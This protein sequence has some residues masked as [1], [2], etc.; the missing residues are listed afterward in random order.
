MSAWSD[1]EKTSS[2]HIATVLL[3]LIIFTPGLQLELLFHTTRFFTVSIFQSLIKA[4][5][6]GITLL[7]ISTP[8]WV[9]IIEKT[10]GWGDD[11]GNTYLLAISFVAIFFVSLCSSIVFS[12]IYLLDIE[13]SQR[14]AI[15]ALCIP[16][17]LIPL[18]VLLYLLISSKHKKQKSENNK[19]LRL[20]PGG[21]QPAQTIHSA[22]RRDERRSHLLS[23]QKKK[24]ILTRMVFL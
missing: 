16:A 6:I 22:A 3:P 1:I 24:T 8:L 20:G 15:S 18:F 19:S 14:T 17:I 23:C 11:D 9:G 2:R 7:V 4:A 13:I 5:V 12:G 21:E 10:G